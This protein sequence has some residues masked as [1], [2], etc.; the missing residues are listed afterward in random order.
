MNQRP[1]QSLIE[2]VALALP[3]MLEPY[4]EKDW[5]VVQVIRAIGEISHHEFEVIFSGGTAL[6]K[7][8]GLLQR[9]SEDIDFRVRVPETSGNRKALSTYRHAVV[10]ALRQQG[11]IID[12][13]KVR[14]RDANRFFCIDM[15]YESYFTRPNSLRPHIQIEL[16][17][18][19][20]QLPYVYLPVSSFINELSKKPPEVAR[21]ACIDPVE[22]AADKL[23]ALAWRIP[24][25]VRGTSY[26][27]PAIV[28][29]IHDLAMLENRVM[30]HADFTALV[31]KSMQ[32]DNNRS[33]S[34]T[35]FSGMSMTEKFSRM[36]GVLENDAEYA[37]EYNRFVKEVSY[38]P[39]GIAPD[40]DTALGAVKRLIQTVAE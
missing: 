13:A 9:F 25:R 31:R 40:F 37:N 38:A 21:I 5:H 27:D 35:S 4:V 19:D 32:D 15:D 18:R 7:A 28:R 24:D 14:A 12:D 11:F 33:K 1:E 3:G 30:D 39:E 29:H 26:D 20:T 34:D 6:S 17:A 16:I 8:H 22:S 36:L 23:S 2:D 10:D